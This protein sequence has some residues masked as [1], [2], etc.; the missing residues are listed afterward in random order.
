MN[1][2]I[3]QTLQPAYAMKPG[4]QHIASLHACAGLEKLIQQYR[5]KRVLELGAGIGTLTD[6]LIESL[7]PDAVIVT[8]EDH[9]YCLEQMRNNLGRRLTRVTLVHDLDAVERDGFDLVVV[10][11][12]R[13]DISVV[14][15]VASRGFVFVEGFRGEQRKF[16]EE[17][18]RPYA[19]ANVRAMHRGG[20]V[21]G[22]HEWGGAYWVYRFEPT[23]VERTRFA[24]LHVWKS[25]LVTKRRA[26]KTLWLRLSWKRELEQT[27]IY[28]K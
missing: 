27:R 4:S 28:Q 19:F 13:A 18:R 9:P 21:H 15:F 3:A 20:S 23:L 22:S 1:H 11:G 5:P 25:L 24:L 2:M 17:S 26:L 16:I 6:L 10:D 8:V 7:T 14:P 12:G